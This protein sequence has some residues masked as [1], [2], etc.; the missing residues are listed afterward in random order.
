MF[1]DT[2]HQV[3]FESQNNYAGS[4][5]LKHVQILYSPDK[6]NFIKDIAH[7]LVVYFLVDND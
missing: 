5:L 7:M 1:K 3:G 4:V 2:F 6:D